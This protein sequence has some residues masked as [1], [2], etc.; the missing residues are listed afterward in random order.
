MICK[1]FNAKLVKVETK[2]LQQKLQNELK[3]HGQY[4]YWTAGYWIDQ[5][6]YAWNSGKRLLTN[7]PTALVINKFHKIT[8]W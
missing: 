2:E 5:R 1:R 8:S 6:K 7:R 4:T 3:K